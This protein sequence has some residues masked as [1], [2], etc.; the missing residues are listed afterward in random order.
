MDP[1]V[2]VPGLLCTGALF[3]PQL[4]VL[5]DR[6]DC[7]IADHTGHDSM[8]AI[9]KSVLEAAPDRF[10]LAGL[11]MGGYIALEMAEMA[12]GRI[13]SLVLLDTSARPEHP[14]QTEFRRKTIALAEE[15]GIGAAVERLLPLFIDATRMQ[16][17]ELVAVVYKM[18][19]DTGVATFIRQQTAIMGR[20]DARPNLAKVTAPTLVIVG[21]RDRLTPPDHSA[22][23]AAGIP[24]ARLVTIAECGHLTTLERPEAVNDA[25]LDFLNAAG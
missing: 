3:G 22:E 18:A 11:S 20:R 23:I 25:L 2:F 7:M 5:S 15:Q 24:D 6:A 16:D 12:P 21:D 13:S 4:D 9:A 14:D 10:V 19:E 17:A 8:E 1:I